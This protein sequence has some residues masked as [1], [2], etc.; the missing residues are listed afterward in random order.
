MPDQLVTCRYPLHDCY[1]NATVPII[2]SVT[3]NDNS[4]NKDVWRGLGAITG[5]FHKNEVLSEYTCTAHKKCMA[6]CATNAHQGTTEC[7]AAGFWIYRASS[8]TYLDYH[9]VL[10]LVPVTIATNYY[11][12]M[13]SHII[14]ETGGVISMSNLGLHSLLAALLLPRLCETK[15]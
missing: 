3:T 12:H 4:N 8:S 14:K 6:G 13:Y 10:S 7:I 9:L 1:N 15:I 11:I 2:H 5:S